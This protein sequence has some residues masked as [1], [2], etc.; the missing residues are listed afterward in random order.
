MNNYEARWLNASK[1][2]TTINDLLKTDDTLHLYWDDCLFFDGFDIDDNYKEI[3][4]DSENTSH[5][6]FSGDIEVD[7]GVHETQSVWLAKF[8]SRCKLYKEVAY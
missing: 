2:C 4:L 5:L 3:T 7:E 6:I 8:K 1:I